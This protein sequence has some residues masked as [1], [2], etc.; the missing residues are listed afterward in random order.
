MAKGYDRASSVE[1][2]GLGMLGSFSLAIVGARTVNYVRERRRAAP[3][4]RSWGRR[5]Y[6]WAREDEL[7]VHHF[8]PGVAVA[9]LSGG[10]AI[11][12][13]HDDLAFWL[14]L[15]FG[16]GVGLTCDEL[17]VMTQFGKSY[18]KSEGLA[19]GQAAAAMLG[20]LGLAVRLHHRGRQAPGRA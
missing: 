16:A 9:F 15:P 7:R 20:A 6:R 14:S 5:I 10:V 12:R 18:W 2:A 8:V 13:R 4:V 3:R 11:V 1:R 17:A 19:F